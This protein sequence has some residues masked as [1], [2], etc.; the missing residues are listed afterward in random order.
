MSCLLPGCSH[1]LREEERS[2]T[3]PSSPAWWEQRCCRPACRWQ[4]WTPLSEALR[5]CLSTELRHCVLVCL[6]L[7][8][9]FGSGVTHVLTWALTC[10]RNTLFINVAKTNRRQNMATRGQHP[11]HR[12][13]SDCCHLIL[14]FLCF[15]VWE[16]CECKLFNLFCYFCVWAMN[17]A[18]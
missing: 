17:I 15:C 6:F 1:C 2:R 8:L 9:S 12:K 13:R 4:T 7:W 3:S 16:K 11:S 14:K 5:W 18:T 10:L